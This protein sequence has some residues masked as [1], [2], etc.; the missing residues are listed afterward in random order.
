MWRQKKKKMKRTKA[1]VVRRNIFSILVIILRKIIG[2]RKI[3][4]NLQD[5][6]KVLRSA[7]LQV[8]TVQQYARESV[9]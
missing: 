1:R 5:L 9:T 7:K 2:T 8:E 3:F 6:F 4:L